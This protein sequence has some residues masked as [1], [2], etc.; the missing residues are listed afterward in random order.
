MQ[1]P[2]IAIR[3]LAKSYGKNA[4]L[5]GVDLEVKRG[6]IVALLGPNGAGKTTAVG[7]LTT[8]IAPDAGTVHLG[9]ID[10]VA[11]PRA[12]RTRV[13]VTGQYASVD[14]FQTGE[15]NLL[16]MAALNG[17]S[18]RDGKRRTSELL[19][20]FDLTAAS[21]RQV[22]TYSGGMRRRLDLASSLVARRPVLVLDEPT[23]GLDPASRMDLWDVVADLAREGTTILLT[24]QYL[25]EADHL[26][27]RITVLDGGRIVAEGTAAALKA[28]VSREAGDQVRLVLDD[29]RSFDVARGLGLPISTVDER[30]LSV[31]V[32]AESSVGTVREL[33]DLADAHDLAVDSVAIVRP[34][35]DDVFLALTG[36]RRTTTTTP[37]DEPATTGANR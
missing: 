1:D 17:L 11:S 13:A 19:E 23:T 9:G 30:G 16:Q 27:D 15:E 36:A 20:R 5:R 4:V 24:T 35:L 25:E 14:E 2:M 8:L 29:A 33:L 3:G 26:A 7:I 34:S 32:R 37:A 18:K 28:R 31:T 21:R 6:E 22:G 10:V 12:A